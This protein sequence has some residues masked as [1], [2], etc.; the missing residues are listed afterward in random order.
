MLRITLRVAVLLTVWLGATHFARAD[1]APCWTYYDPAEGHCI[2]SGGCEDYYPQ[3]ECLIGCTPGWCHSGDGQDD[4]CGTIRLYAIGYNDGDPEECRSLEC[5]EVR[6]RKAHIQSLRGNLVNTVF[7]SDLDAG[8]SV[9]LPSVVLV[10]NRCTHAYDVVLANF[11]TPTK[12]T[13]TNR[14]G[15]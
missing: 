4:C 10:P 3:T 11:P 2:G 14:K 6:Q 15:L 13:P 12:P 5:G 8:S 7:K 9:R 1:E